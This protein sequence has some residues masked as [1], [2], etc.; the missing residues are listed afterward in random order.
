MRD[1]GSTEFPEIIVL[2]RKRLKEYLDAQKIVILV[3]YIA[4][5][6]IFT[7]G[8]PRFAAITVFPI[9][10]WGLLPFVFTIRLPFKVWKSN[11]KFAFAIFLA[12]F[13]VL[14]EES[15]AL[16][17]IFTPGPNQSRLNNPTYVSLNCAGGS[18][19]AAEEAIAVNA[20]VVFLQESPSADSL[21]SLGEQNGYQVFAGIDGSVLLKDSFKVEEVI[22]EQNFTL[23]RTQAEIFVSIRLQPP[24]FRLDF[25][26]AECWTNQAELITLRRMELVDILET[27]EKQR[28]LVEVEPGPYVVVAGDF[29]A[30]PSLLKPNDVSTGYIDLAQWRGKGWIGSAVN[31]FPLVRIDRIWIWGPGAEGVGELQVVSKKTVNSD[32][33]MVVVY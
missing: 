6:A 4:L 22:K 21:K 15:W 19:A 11:F 18:E 28:N 23:I 25:Y 31:D 14:S 1:Q 2:V 30:P 26:N 33:R 7:I 29:N 10:A 24:A 17:R 3:L 16:L 8:S 20:D 9:W 5:M 27:V 13:V 32:H 12:I